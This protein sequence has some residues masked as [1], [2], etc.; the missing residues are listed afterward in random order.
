MSEPAP[1][2]KGWTQL[3]RILGDNPKQPVSILLYQ[4]TERRR[5]PDVFFFSF[6]FWSSSIKHLAGIPPLCRTP[7][8][9]L[10]AAESNEH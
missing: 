7:W 5:N 8:V 3:V 6:L 10:H 9:L 4:F 1:S 2:P